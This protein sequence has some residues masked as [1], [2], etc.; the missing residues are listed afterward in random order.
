MPD[1]EPVLLL[2]IRC[3]GP[4]CCATFFIC[5]HCYR[6]QCYCGA[7]CRARSRLRQRRAANARYQRSEAG[8]L[9]HNDRQSLY[10]DRQRAGRVTDLS[11][12]QPHSASLCN[13]DAP[14]PVPPQPA[15]PPTPSRPRIRA[16]PPLRCS[17]GGRPGITLGFWRLYGYLFWS[18][19]FTPTR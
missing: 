3:R 16:L 5:R 17:L 19:R 10:R 9:D 1:G 4:N 14:A 2:A 8:R 15:A 12:A 7:A 11:S 18:S 13:H 6:G